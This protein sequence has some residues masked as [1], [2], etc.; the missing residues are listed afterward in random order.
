M[1]ILDKQKLV[2]VSIPKSGTHTM[3][4]ILVDQFGGTRINPP[5]H[6]RNIPPRCSGY[7]TFAVVRNPYE[8]A[9]SIWYHLLYRTAQPDSSIKAYGETWGP[10]ISQS[11]EVEIDDLTIEHVFRFI[12]DGGCKK[13]R[14]S[15]WQASLS[16]SEWLKNVK[17]DNW[18]KIENLEAEM[19]DILG[20]EIT[21]IRKQFKGEY[22]HP[23]LTAEGR[24]LIEEW[25][26]EDF[27]RFGYEKLT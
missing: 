23:K 22:K 11:A 21:P 25:A 4:V 13:Y 20:L 15:G 1:V 19:N 18:I 12:V 9:I 26:S 14:E 2:W 8:R 6:P 5:F 24:G 10:I 17:I 7:K 16:Q 3:I 27:N